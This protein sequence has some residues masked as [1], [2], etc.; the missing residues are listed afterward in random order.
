M[1]SCSGTGGAE[2][3]RRAAWQRCTQSSRVMGVDDF[4]THFIVVT[5]A[6]V[7]N[8]ENRDNN[9]GCRDYMVYRFSLM[10]YRLMNGEQ[11]S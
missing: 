7:Y 1:G 6:N 5:Y 2:A 4:V 3:A 11:R 9:A 8:I 10:L